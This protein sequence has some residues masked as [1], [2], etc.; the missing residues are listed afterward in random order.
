MRFI[1]TA[2]WQLGMTAHFLG[3]DA[4]PRYQQAR[5]DAVRRI[6]QL[7]AEVGAAFVVV[8]GDVF[9]SNQLDRSVV[10]RAF[11]ALR[12]YP[13][14]V[15]LVPGNHDPLDAVSLYD[16]LA[17]A[18]A[19]PQLRV[20]RSTAPLELAPGVEVVPVPWHSKFPGA[21]LVA[22]A[23]S[24]LAAAADGV[25][26]VLVGHGGV[27]TLNPDQHAA[28]TVDVPAL[29]ESLTVG[30]VHVAVLGDR[31]STTRVSERIWYP[32]TPEV[33]RRTEVDPGNVLVIDLDPA[34]GAVAVQPHRVGRW[35]FTVVE[36][37]LDSRADVEALAARLDA[38]AHKETTAVWLALTGT[39]TAADMA[40]LD[41][42]LDGA[43]PL[44]ALLDH[45][46]RHR[47]LAVMPDDA[48]FAELGLA[49]FMKDAVDELSQRR[50]DPAA[51][52]ALSLLYR[53]AGGGR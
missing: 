14:P 19:P 51:Q 29:E 30:K 32:G 44:F 28:D 26:R 38:I 50:E 43:A 23:C 4:R 33:T 8:G 15:L 37:R 27:S 53:L 42:V 25:A 6:G 24:Q 40:L 21:D 10:A 9:E 52:D 3:A 31:H 2:D 36:E 34:T 11:E 12:D 5:F 35:T 18:Q 16:S 45:W 49:G 41:E 48:D 39:L 47:E 22:H 46:E 20:A 13:V 7:A 17:F 1:A